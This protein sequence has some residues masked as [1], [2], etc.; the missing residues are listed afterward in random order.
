MKAFKRW[1]SNNIHLMKQALKFFSRK[2]LQLECTV[3]N[4][5][6]RNE[7]ADIIIVNLIV[8]RE[9]ECMLLKI[10]FLVQKMV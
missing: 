5:S 2:Q 9:L 7:V 3:W 8:K 1:G 6:T 4:A 10:A